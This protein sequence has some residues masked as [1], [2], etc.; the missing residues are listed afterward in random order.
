MRSPKLA[1][2]SEFPI[3]TSLPYLPLQE[4][5]QIGPW[6][7][8]PLD[9]FEGAWAEPAFE[10]A[11]RG[12]LGAF[13]TASGEPVRNPAIVVRDGVVS[14]APPTAAE[15]SALG[16]AIGLAVVDSNPTWTEHTRHHGYRMA[17]SDNAELWIQPLDTI[18]GHIAL[19]RGSRVRTTVGGYRVTDAGFTIPAPLELTLPLTADVD[20][21]TANALYSVLTGD[22]SE[23]VRVG[24]AV[25]WLLKSWRNSTSISEDDRIVFLKTALEAL[26]GPARPRRPEVRFVPS[27]L[28]PPRR[29]VRGSARMLCCGDP[30]SRSSPAR[31]QLT[32]SC[33]PPT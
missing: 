16:R 13:R 31:G 4:P 33:G 24:T 21:V 18:G 25:D 8:T 12:F 5:V 30:T 22:A 10:T 19:E 26:T 9:K 2:V 1:P 20:D 11:A 7:V 27:S 32:A 3:L 28:A 29:M 15:A 17:T 6:T 14:A 23:S